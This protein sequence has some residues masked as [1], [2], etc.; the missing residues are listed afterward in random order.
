M[1]LDVQSDTMAWS[2]LLELIPGG[3]VLISAD[4]VTLH[5]N[6]TARQVFDEYPDAR[7]LA[8]EGGGLLH[9]AALRICVQSVGENRLV[10][11]ESAPLPARTDLAI[12]MSTTTQILR[13][14]GLLR[15]L[16]TTGTTLVDVLDEADQEDLTAVLKAGGG[17]LDGG[18]QHK[19]RC[20][21]GS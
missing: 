18:R 5:I 2:P 12:V 16:V 1:S 7:T 6:P 20:L 19:L 9:A 4:G 8:L 17:R 21:R 14:E 3:V 11:M 13:S 15:E 10:T